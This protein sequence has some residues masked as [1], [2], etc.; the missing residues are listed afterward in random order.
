MSDKLR[1]V[2]T[3][4]ACPEQYDVFSGEELIGYMRLRWGHFRA[5]YLGKT[6]YDASTIGH[7]SFD[8]TERHRHLNAGCTAILAAAAEANQPEPPEE[9]ALYDIECKA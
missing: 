2:Q 1:L 9:P 6:V 4:A 8:D 7:G 5:E 3:C